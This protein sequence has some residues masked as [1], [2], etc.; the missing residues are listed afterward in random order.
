MR[1]VTTRGYREGGEQERKLAAGDIRDAARKLAA[2]PRTQGVLQSMAASW[3]EE[4]KTR[5]S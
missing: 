3:E 5:G 2:W 1:G 4:A